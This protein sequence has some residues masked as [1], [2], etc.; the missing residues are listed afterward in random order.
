MHWYAIGRSLQ[1]ADL[2]NGVNQRL[3]MMRS[4]AAHQRSINIEKDQVSQQ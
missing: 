3:P 2:P 4:G 1:T